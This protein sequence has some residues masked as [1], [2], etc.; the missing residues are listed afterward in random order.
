MNVTIY[1]DLDQF[2]SSIGLPDEKHG[3]RGVHHRGV[4]RTCKTNNVSQYWWCDVPF[5]KEFEQFD[6][7]WKA[8]PLLRNETLYGVFE[9]RRMF[10]EQFRELYAQQKIVKDRE[11]ELKQ[12]EEL[13]FHTALRD[14]IDR[15]TMFYYPKGKLETVHCYKLTSADPLLPSLL[16]NLQCMITSRGSV[17]KV[18][19]HEHYL[20]LLEPL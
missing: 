13:K 3:S 5:T 20:L 7:A 9:E 10:A 11:Q 12:A 1:N 14:W 18:V 15:C 19:Q 4:M 2:V 6:E 17:R 8:N 16:N